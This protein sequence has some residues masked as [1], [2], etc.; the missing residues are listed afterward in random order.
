MKLELDMTPDEWHVLKSELQNYMSCMGVPATAIDPFMV[1]A[2]VCNAI[3][4]ADG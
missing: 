4:A 3:D 1:M 2:K